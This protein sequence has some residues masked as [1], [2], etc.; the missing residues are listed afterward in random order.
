[1]S[2]KQQWLV[3]VSDHPGTIQKRIEVR[4]QH[5]SHAGENQA[6]VAGG[7]PQY[8]LPPFPLVEEKLIVGAF[9]S[10]EPTADD[11]MPFAVFPPLRNGC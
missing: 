8:Q 6:V 9:F 10:K 5:L 1:M 4:P 11:P 7:T 2:S 3:I